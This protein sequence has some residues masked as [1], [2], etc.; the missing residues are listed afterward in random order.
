[1]IRTPVKLQWQVEPSGVEPDWG[2]SKRPTGNLLAPQREPLS[3][4]SQEP[5]AGVSRYLGTR[6][7]GTQ[8]IAEPD[9]FSRARSATP[10]PATGRSERASDDLADQRHQMEGG[11]RRKHEPVAR[12]VDQ[13]RALKREDDRLGVASLGACSSR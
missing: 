4:G 11:G 7:E 3:D 6:P 9:Y 1:M 13:P 8:M 10:S 12:L 5:K 2:S